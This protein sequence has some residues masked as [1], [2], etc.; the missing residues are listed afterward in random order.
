MRIG[1]DARVLQEGTGGVFVYA[2]NVLTHLA[3]LGRSHDINLFANQYHPKKSDALLDL[4]AY[5]NVRLHQYRFP[6]KFLNAS[7]KF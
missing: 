6:N 7:F 2:K 3:Q 4:C 5:P 1:I